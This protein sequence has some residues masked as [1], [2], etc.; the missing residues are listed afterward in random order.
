MKTLARVL[1]LLFPLAVHAADDDDCRFRA[2]RAAEASSDGIRRIVVKAGSGMLDIRGESGR[3]SID[4]SGVACA[5]REA[6]LEKLQIRVERDG[7]RLLISTDM[8][9]ATF[10]PSSW[11]GSYARLDL[12]LRVPAGIALDVDDGSGE[13]RISNVG[14]L[15]VTDGSGSLHIENVQGNVDANDGSGEMTIAHV[16]GSVRVR[17]GSGEIKIEDING[18]LVI[19]ED[20]SGAITI[21]KVQGNVTIGNDGSGEIQIADVTGSVKIEDD[22]SGD[23]R[24]VRVK[25]D[26]TIENDGSGEIVVE[27][28]EGDLAIYNSGS[29]GV[30]HARV[31]GKVRVDNVDE[32]SDD[33]DEPR[34]ELV[35]RG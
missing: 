35:E 26:V 15:H 3:R 21:D 29:G 7:D 9:E 12:S 25:H 34:D 13:A 14:D 10:S 33:A 18:E 19:V 32:S 16:Q 5:S 24:I 23:I 2:D 8:P 4:A 6:Q 22:G 31:R 30:R 11:F 20:G 27:D 1:C 17:D 28:V